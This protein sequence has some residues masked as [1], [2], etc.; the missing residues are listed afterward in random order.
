[1]TNKV[2]LIHLYRRWNIELGQFHGRKGESIICNLRWDGTGWGKAGRRGLEW[3]VVG[4]G[5]SVKPI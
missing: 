3:S 2:V 5:K 4:C 1:M